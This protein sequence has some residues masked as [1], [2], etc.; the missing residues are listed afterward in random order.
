MASVARAIEQAASKA[1]SGELWWEPHTTVFYELDNCGL[2]DAHGTVGVERGNS[3][4]E[5]QLVEKLKANHG[6]LLNT[7]LS[8]KPPNE[9][10]KSALA[11]SRIDVGSHSLEIKPELRDIALQVSTHLVLDEVQAY[12][13]LSRHIESGALVPFSADRA[14]LQAI[15]L[16]YYVERQCLLKS[17][18]LL[19]TF[20]MADEGESLSSYKAMCLEV[21]QLLE[22]G[23]EDKTLANLKD[24]LAVVQP[25]H[26]D[27]EY[28]VF[29][30]EETVLEQSLLLDVLFLLYYEPLNSC[31]AARFKELLS[32]FQG[33]VFGSGH[34]ERLVFS[35]E[36]ARCV[37]HVRQQAVLILIEA[38]DLENLLLMV[39]DE[40]P[41]S[42]GGHTFSVAEVQE[43]D[44]IIGNLDT[45]EAPE[46]APLLLGWATFLCL[47]SFLPVS[48]DQAPFQE[49]DLS[50]CVR[51]AY[52]G[53]AYSYLLEMLR[54][55]SFQESDVQVGGYKSVV[56]TLAAAFLAAF[57]SATRMDYEGYDILINIF[58]EIY[59]G[60]ESL[61]LELW[62]RDS[63][64]DGPI[65]NLLFTLRED[66]PY[67]T[68]SLVRLLA[69]Q[70]KGPWP[71]ECVYDFL[72]KMVKVTSL[73]QHPEGAVMCEK[74]SV[75]QTNVTLLVPGAPGLMIPRGT[76]GRIS[77]V[78]DG[79]V[80]LVHWECE[81]SGILILLLRMLQRSASGYLLEEVH[82]S[83]DLLQQMLSS[84]KVLAQL[85]LDLDGAV[86]TVT[87]RRDGRMEDF[88]RIDVVA[89]ICAIING[90]AQSRGNYVMLSSCM[91]ILGS[92]A[93]CSPEQVMEELGRTSLLQPFGSS[94]GGEWVST[95]SLLQMLLQKVEP[96]IG[97]Y[98]LALAALGFTKT[99]VEKGVESEM[100][101]S[102]VMYMVRELLLNHGNWKYQQ[103]HQRWQITT[104][105]L[106][107][108]LS[109]LTGTSS[110]VSTGNL[111]RVLLETFLFD[112]IIQ[113]FIF[114]I[115]SIGS[116]LEELHYNRSVRPRELEWVQYALHTVLLLLHHVLL[117]AT[118]GPA[119]KDYPGM[120][121]LEQSLLRKFA[122]PLPVVAIIASF[123]SFSRNADMQLASV[124]ALT[125]LC[126]SAQKARPH[127][128]SIAS[129]ISSPDQRKVLR[130]VICQFL[131]EEG[132]VSHQEL[133]IAIIELLTTAVK[134]QPSLVALFLFPAEQ[135]LSTIR[136][137]G[138]LSAAQSAHS[139]PS[140]ADH[141]SGVLDVLWKTILKS[142]ELVKSHPQMLSRVLFLL[143]SIWQEGIEYLRIIETLRQKPNFWRNLASGLSFISG[144]TT[145]PIPTL[146]QNTGDLNKHEILLQAFRYRCEASILTIM[147]CDVFLQKCLLY[148]T[149]NEP[150]TSG[151]SQSNNKS[152]SGESATVGSD[153]S[154]IA[155]LPSS[156]SGAFE[157]INEWAK[158][159][160]TS[161]ILKSYTFCSYDQEVILRAK[162]EARVLIVGMM[163]KVLAGDVRGI[164]AALLERLRQT[165]TQVFQLSSFEELVVQYTA[166]GYSHGNQLQVMLMSD[167][168]H[169][170]QGEIV[171]G[172]PLPTG[173]FQ[174]IAAFLLTKEMELLGSIGKFPI[175]EGLHPAYGNGYVYDTKALESELGLEWWSQTETAILP[176]SVVERSISYLEQANTMA[177]LGH[178]QL[179]ALRAWAAVVTVCI[180]DKQGVRS[181]AVASELEWNDEDVYR[182]TEDLCEA[183][184]SAV[185]AI[186]LAKDTSNLLPT[187]MAM[188]AHL[189]LI[190][191]RWLWNRVTPSSSRKLR[192]WA[193]CA[194]IV[195]TTVGCL[196]LQLDSHVDFLQQ[197][198]EL[199]KE[200][201]GA[202][203]IALEV[204][205]TQ[206]GSTAENAEERTIEGGHEMGDAFSDVTL[207]GLGFLPGLCTAVE[208]PLY[209]NLAL[210][211]INLLIKGF[212]A[213]TTWMPI[214]QNHFPTQ[215]LIRRIHADVNSESPRV[216]LNICLSLARMRVGAEMLQN[217][218][219]F[220]HLLTLSKQ[221][222]DN[223][224]ISSS[225]EGPFSVWPNRD[226]PSEGHM[227]RLQLAVVTALIRSGGEKILGGSLVESAFT[228]VAA[229]KELLLS[230]LRAPVP[231]LDT[232]GRK[233]AKLQQ[234]RTTISALQEVQHVMSLICELA[235]HQ[236]T[237]GRTL[238]ESITEFEEMSLHLLAYIAREGLVRSGVYH[239]F[240]VGIQCHPVQKEEIIAH[241]RPS[242]VGSCAGWFALCAKGSTVKESNGAASPPPKVAPQAAAASPT[243]S[244]SS[245]S[246]SGLIT[247]GSLPSITSSVTYTEY[248][249]LVAINV[250]RLVLLLLNFNCKQV[251]H[252]VDRFEDRGAIDYSHF[253]QLPA[254]EVLYHLQD[255]VGAVL[256]DILRAREGKVIQEAVKDVCLL[257]FGILEKS[258]YLGVAVC[259]SCGLTPHPLRSDD[260]GKEFRALLSAS[261]NFE[262][263][264]RPLRSLKRVVALAFPEI[265]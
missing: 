12:I 253:P 98:P 71:A 67:Q 214:L 247:S 14:F 56:K 208:H 31:K 85:L 52:D 1:V 119:S 15:T 151:L 28:T 47:V 157:I 146:H 81:H 227:W 133:F 183:L 79:R 25:Q 88:L 69:A 46:Y 90:L 203:I 265:S 104:Q 200:L 38:L 9:A 223:K 210:A 92:F 229:L 63:V 209:A 193:V 138:D 231:G 159:S 255:Q 137:T 241:G 40:T 21:K 16:Y 130:N 154:S 112:S 22:D 152:S 153:T 199:V 122:G 80:S 124:R 116:T 74:G 72:Y 221:L 2:V 144:L 70:C 166:R 217:T 234:P 8:F 201:L 206:N 33:T 54:S 252:A 27:R 100:L 23:F 55:D 65:R 226:Q 263:L 96:S 48:G 230:S 7:L 68:L 189:L 132:W 41:F 160:V 248:S 134:W 158:K 60:Q 111:R 244:S 211:G 53:G 258:L 34:G 197:G 224:V 246:G 149:S 118:V 66:F 57:D 167:L 42:Q 24:R 261:Q 73:Y 204:I 75:L 6:W 114:Q 188:Q 51:Q 187:F 162:A 262:F 161:S 184:E 240:H 36:A 228:Y 260:F 194:K 176:P 61:C 109:V 222:Q 5:A 102:L 236:L 17:C 171:G 178:S 147:A 97:D 145:S 182:C 251:R 93:L 110:R 83:L 235:N 165:M 249:D 155:K 127:S 245:L 219:I 64:I 220:S 239:S 13:L 190:F 164:S 185:V 169:H 238:P 173:P 126:V 131:S 76:Y 181:E 77:R 264:E 125:S 50:A 177:S 254:P 148:P 250:Y 123:L 39:H 59:R 168:Y 174:R 196:K 232:Q 20:Q 19:L 136:V 175:L 108:S 242:F 3:E 4:G 195:R 179:S 95:G 215:S 82:A 86:A 44:G 84:N 198:E 191:A 120:S 192:L 172:R 140:S 117:D 18:Q 87:A 128:V 259:R 43:L 216:A 45:S 107:V 218:G 106:Q 142:N 62:D 101:S 10:S 180:F 58:C 113:D 205:Y 237:W 213:P 233:K 37:A 207:M 99:I 29:W 163:R 94:I 202:F 186:G 243:R 256:I 135:S 11:S 257:L 170:L 35:T 105:T 78:I 49:M 32:C 129:Y 91:H 30:A 89:M 139:G 115:L 141:S 150:T 26:L 143:A 103:P 225:M 156:K 121:L 212:I